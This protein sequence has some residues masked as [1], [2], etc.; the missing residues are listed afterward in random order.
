MK[1]K[2]IVCAVISCVVVV[3]LIATILILQFS[4]MNGEN[5]ADDTTS[6]STNVIDPPGRISIPGFDEIVLKADTWIQNVHFKNPESNRCYF[7]ITLY[8]QDG[9]LLYK[10][11]LIAPGESINRIC[12]SQLLESG[13]Y[14]NCVLNYACYST[15]DFQQ[16]NGINT[17]FTLEVTK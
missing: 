4:D 14:E 9:S 3:A 15:K 11:D 17:I 7:V 8:M 1:K 10:S 12:L 16:L 13:V 2:I 6:D 5:P